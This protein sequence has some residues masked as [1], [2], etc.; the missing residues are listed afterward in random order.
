MFFASLPPTTLASSSSFFFNFDDGDDDE[1]D[2]DATGMRS[3]IIVDDVEGQLESQPQSA[4][5]GY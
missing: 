5:S 2:D 1:G 4:A 3:R